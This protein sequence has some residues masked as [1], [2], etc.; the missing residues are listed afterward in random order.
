MGSNTSCTSNN[1]TTAKKST[2]TTTAQS[3]MMMS[4]QSQPP[5]GILKNKNEKQTT[6]RNVRIQMCDVNHQQTFA[7]QSPP[8]SPMVEI[9]VQKNGQWRVVKVC[10]VS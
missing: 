2:T 8:S 5:K 10:E 6:D 7:K 4:V 9:Y 1:S 3:N